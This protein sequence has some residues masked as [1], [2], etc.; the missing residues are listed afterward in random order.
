MRIIKRMWWGSIIVA[1]IAV[2]ITFK[3]NAQ[4]PDSQYFSETNHYVRGEFLTFFRSLPDPLLILGY[5]ITEEE[6]DPSTGKTVQYFQVARLEL[7]LTAKPGKRVSISNL[8]WMMYTTGALPVQI[9]TDSPTCRYFPKNRVSVCYAFLQFY[10]S[11][12]GE[13]VF[14]EPISALEWRDS[15]MVQ[16]FENARMEWRPEAPVGKRVSLTHLG[17]LYFDRVL[18]IG[19]PGED[20]GYGIGGTTA[21]PVTSIKA[22][23]FV[24]NALLAPSSTQTLYVIVQDQSLRPVQNAMIGVVV[25][26]PDGRQSYY[27]PEST[28]ANGIS[29]FS[30]DA[31]Q[32]GLKKIVQVEVVA[33]YGDL[34]Q[35]ATTWFRVWW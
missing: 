15:H 6:Q 26:E 25:T 13:S 18:G 24:K 10:D 17:R 3:A 28:N 22:R 20:K 31:G 35:R 19:G 27:R 11:N 4:T 23:A 2:G 7:D 5:P 14:G 29:I 8:G 30:F 32:D 16:Y 34:E 12:G 33:T 9:S 21:P 1:L